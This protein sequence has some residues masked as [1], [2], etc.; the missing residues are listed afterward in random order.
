MFCAFCS[1]VASGPA[2]S[3]WGPKAKNINEAFF[4]SFFFLLKKIDHLQESFE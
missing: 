2:Q 4:F 3:F 1:S